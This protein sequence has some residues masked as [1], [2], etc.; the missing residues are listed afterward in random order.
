MIQGLRVVSCSFWLSLVL[1]KLNRSLRVVHALNLLEI[2]QETPNLIR[3]YMSKERTTSL[4]FEVN[5][6]SKKIIPQ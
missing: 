4:K 5:K 1:R 6:K 3:L 2:P